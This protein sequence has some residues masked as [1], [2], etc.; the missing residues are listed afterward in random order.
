MP[1]SQYVLDAS[2]VINLYQHFQARRV[3]QMLTAHAGRKGV[4]IPEGVQRELMRHS[5]A[6]ATT[7]AKLAG[8]Q[9]ECIVRF[10]Q[11]PELLGQLPEMERKYGEEIRVEK[12]TYN[13]FWKSPAGHNAADGQVVA[14]ARYFRAT[15][16]SEDRAIELACMLENVPCIGWS[17]FAR[18]C[19]LA[20]HTQ[21][22]LF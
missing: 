12:K 1:R 22:E 15:A 16:V 9:H 7:M 6:A 4:R 21:R 11:H 13:G 17:E 10:K 20:R 2:A 14:V 5:D 18:L 3:S 19:G 8:R